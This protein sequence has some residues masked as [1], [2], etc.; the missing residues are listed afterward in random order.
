MKAIILI[1]LVLSLAIST[2]APANG[3]KGCNAVATNPCGGSAV[4]TCN[5]DGSCK[6]VKTFGFDCS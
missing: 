5:A 3:Y 4:G 1:S 2:A 6:C